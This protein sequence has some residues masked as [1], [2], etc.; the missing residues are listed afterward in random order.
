MK[1]TVR[2]SS[3]IGILVFFVIL[4]NDCFFYYIPSTVYMSETNKTLITV[5]AI[6][7][8]VY[9]LINRYCK[10]IVQ[11]KSGFT[12]RYTLTYLFIICIIAIYSLFRYDTEDI[13]AMMNNIVPYLF[14]LFYAPVMVLEHERKEIVWKMLNFY[15]IIWTILI[16][17]QVYLYS[18][19]GV[20]FMGGF[21]N[22][23]G[24][25]E[26]RNGGM[27]LLHGL[28][29]YN[30]MVLYNF[31]KLLDETNNKKDR[32]LH[33]VLAACGFYIVFFVEQ[34]RAMTVV[35]IVIIIAI[36]LYRR[37]TTTG[38]ITNILMMAGL[39]IVLFATS[40][41]S[42]L[43][44]SITSV[45]TN[46]N[47]RRYAVGHFMNTFFSNPLV[48]IGFTN[49]KLLVH[50]ELGLAF[51]DDVG[52]F[53]QLARLGICFLIIYIPIIVRLYTIQKKLRKR[54]STK[55]D[56]I[57]M[58]FLYALLTSGSLIL[59][60]PQRIAL[61]PIIIGTAENEYKDL[62]EQSLLDGQ[63]YEEG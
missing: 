28:C 16:F 62:I 26:Y 36:L 32:L 13:P 48:G 46:N 9:C 10:S 45:S 53:G 41:V 23:W 1:I 7:L 21:T 47:M 15:F 14:L 18:L 31:C 5:I 6:L 60:D 22:R 24:N 58:L 4:A 43:I 56:F 38:L 11:T 17:A 30:I 61:L 51:V 40:Y 42:Y 44:K 27:R 37:L 54:N 25:V 49:D 2:V 50:G 63:K 34:S 52:I 29:F 35:I 55:A 39:A 33:G 19:S 3:L 20:V 57:F 12:D 8:F 59:F